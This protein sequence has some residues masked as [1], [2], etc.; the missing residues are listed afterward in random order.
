MSDV[1]AFATQWGF[2]PTRYLTMNSM[3]DV[4]EF[5]D[6]VGTTGE[7]EGEAIEGFVVRTTMP[8]APAPA[9][10]D[11]V[12]AAVPPP[13]AP[14]QTWFYKVK[15]DDPYLMYRDWRE[16]AKRMLV[17]RNKWLAERQRGIDREADA[18]K[19][20]DELVKSASRL[21]IDDPSPV[22]ADEA[23][24]SKNQ[25]KK[26]KK[27]RQNEIQRSLGPASGAPTPPQA[28]KARSDR[29]ETKL[30]VQWCWDRMYGS[31]DGRVRAQPALFEGL[32]VGK[33][34]IR[35]RDTFLAYLETSEGRD[36]LAA[37][38]GAKGALAARLG[39]DDSTTSAPTSSTSPDTR[40]YTHLLVLPISLPGAGKTTLFHSLSL[41]YPRALSHTQSDDVPTKKSG[42]TFL[43]NICS[44]LSR[45]RVVLADRNNHL[46]QHRDE[47]VEA[48]RTWE[49]RGGR[50][51]EQLRE[52]KKKHFQKYG[53]K[54][55]APPFGEEVPLEQRPRV[56]FLTLLYELDILPF[57][58]LHR[59]LSDRIL[60]RGDNHQ[61]LVADTSA[62][63]GCRAHEV[64]LWRF[65]EAYEPF[66][67]AEGKGEGTKGWG[68]VVLRQEGA[69]VTLNVEECLREQLEQ[70]WRCL[71]QQGVLPR[72]GCEELE[73]TVRKTTPAMLDEA[74]ERA[75]GYKATQIKSLLPAPG[76]TN[77]SVTGPRYYA[78]SVEVDLA[79][80]LPPL[81][82][83]KSPQNREPQR[84]ARLSRARALLTSLSVSKRVVTRPH[85]T[86]VHNSALR[87]DIGGDD[88]SALHSLPEAERKSIQAA[89][90]KW[91]RYEALCGAGEAGVDFDVQFGRLCWEGDKVMTLSVS[92]VAPCLDSALSV[93]E[94]ERLQGEG[95]EWR[96]HI[97]VGTRDADVRPFEANR[98]VRVV[99]TLRKEGMGDG[100]EGEIEWIDLDWLMSVNGRLLGMSA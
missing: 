47:V 87:R 35:L 25:L 52:E 43:R 5:T 72:E 8:D 37:L 74:I 4:K 67:S 76:S 33:G 24:K 10:A 17:D 86:L 69:S 83:A 48:V 40:P 93:E 7:Y 38:G 60:G 12:K 63:A 6:R 96:P 20:P 81:L 64:V 53:K 82:E 65:L 19:E 98:V 78:I 89:R 41:L 79:R 92:F 45:S 90:R 54:K 1:N 26:E 2:I 36:R 94:M 55:G 84:A 14:G 51:E 99:D 31:Q 23:Q 21:E 70:V 71:T 30:F 3:A 22:M 80:L 28:P 11:R 66:D 16:L 68:D 13:Y 85:I 42:P 39:Q 88:E 61:S 9:P 29:P 62:A 73:E 75:R 56:K 18:G 58:A 27:A 95:E 100:E 91:Q 49:A 97:T 44:E 50:S 57:N 46:L 34:I 77:G 32:N 15:F 59:L